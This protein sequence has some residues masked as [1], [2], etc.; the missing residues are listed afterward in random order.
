MNRRG[1]L[2]AAVG[3][4]VAP[5]VLPQAVEEKT[6]WPVRYA[7][8]L[9]GVRADLPT[10]TADFDVLPAFW[11]ELMDEMIRQRSYLQGTA[12]QA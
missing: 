5:A 3:A 7:D 1:F 4:V 8:E 10:L 9:R 2:R 6:P 11:Q 12:Q